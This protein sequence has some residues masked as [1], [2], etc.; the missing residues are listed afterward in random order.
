MN[1]NTLTSKA[2][3]NINNSQ[4]QYNKNRLTHNHIKYINSL[5]CNYNINN[6]NFSDDK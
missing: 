3:I 2:T 4:Q 6:L 5:V 1:E